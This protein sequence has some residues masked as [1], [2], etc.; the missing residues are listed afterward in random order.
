MDG[1]GGP[2]W[3]MPGP[4]DTSSYPA[5]GYDCN[6]DDPDLGPNSGC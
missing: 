5:L 2:L 3:W 4:Y 6:D 1:E